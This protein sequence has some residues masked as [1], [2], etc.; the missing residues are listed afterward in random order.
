MKN[1]N[2]DLWN[3]FIEICKGLNAAGITPTLMGS[4][5]LEAVTKR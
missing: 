4:L 1:T 5:G 3:C 2:T